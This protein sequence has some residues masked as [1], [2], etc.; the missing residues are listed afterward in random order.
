M[1]KRLLLGFV[2]AAALMGA[3]AP[4]AGAADVRLD[5]ISGRANIVSGDDARVAIK[6]RRGVSARGLRVTLGK[7][8]VSKSFA[9]R[10]NG[11]IEGLLEGLPS[12]SRRL[13]ARLRNGS[14]ARITL[15]NHPGGRAR[16]L[17]PAD[18][19][20]E[21]REGAT[22]RQCNRPVS[23]EFRYKS[24][25]RGRAAGLRPE[26]PALGR[27]HHHYRPGSEGAVHRAPGDRR[28]S[29]A[30]STASRCCSSRA[31]RGSHGRRS[32]ASTTSS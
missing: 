22:D 21:V 20:M 17:G 25:G 12:G 29:T 16:Y 28:R 10:A 13:T 11:R 6:V 24:D 2:G 19:A 14:G 9:R 26:E 31:S 5:V 23:Y 32:P 27:G 7:R 4:A 18:P 15:T 3:A 30:T 1:C 8:N